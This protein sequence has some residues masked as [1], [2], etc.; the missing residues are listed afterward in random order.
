M[1][2]WEEERCT[3]QPLELQEVSE[4]T[5][6]QRKDIQEVTE[7]VDGEE[8]NYWSCL[9]RFISKS[10]YQNLKAIEEIDTSEAVAS[11]IDDYTC[12]LL[13]GGII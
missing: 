12:E 3:S 11:A 4:S 10:D 8:V 9:A 13:E 5:Y 6:I 1:T 2:P 7:E